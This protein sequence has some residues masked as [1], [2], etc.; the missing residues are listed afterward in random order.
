MK[1]LAGRRVIAREEGVCMDDATSGGGRVGG[2]GGCESQGGGGGAE[3]SPLPN[4]PHPVG[5]QFLGGHC[6]LHGREA[7]G[8]EGEGEPPV[9]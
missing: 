9:P 4:G 6:K 8:G 5:A 3:R 2:A 1:K 7:T